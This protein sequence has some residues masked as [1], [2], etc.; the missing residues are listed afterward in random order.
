MEK[1]KNKYRIPS[2]RA[3]WHNY[4]GGVYFVTI[5]TYAK[6]YYF[7]DIDNTPMMNL[8][9][10]G[11]FTQDIFNNVKLFYPYAEIPLFVV[12]PNH[13]HA[14]VFIDNHTFSRRDAIHRVSTTKIAGGITTD[15]NP[16][17]QQSLGTV[18]RGLKARITYYA[19][20]NNIEFKWQ[21]R[22]HDRIIRNQTELNKMAI[23]IENNITDWHLNT[24]KKQ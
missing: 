8:S 14:I 10:I 3:N 2:A 20:Q 6:I 17:L 7:G 4:T 1:F 16:I 9:K 19:N 22:F 18:L 5:N 11:K 15:K 12:M 23:Y 24:S 21:N 13:I